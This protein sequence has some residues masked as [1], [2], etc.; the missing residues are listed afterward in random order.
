MATARQAFLRSSILSVSNIKSHQNFTS[1][2]D[3]IIG[4]SV[5]YRP[6][7]EEG[8]FLNFTGFVYNST[9]KLG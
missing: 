8:D 7:A 6:L 9:T 4:S 2:N 3:E 1:R 5:V